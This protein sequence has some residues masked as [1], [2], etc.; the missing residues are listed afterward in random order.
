[1][2][3]A[4]SDWSGPNTADHDRPINKRGQKNAMQVGEWMQKN[5][6]I[7]QKII[8]STCIGKY[9]NIF[10]SACGSQNR[11]FSLFVL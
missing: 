7:P 4:K 5:N 1:M 6:Y 11:L 3:H 10:A 2:R 9:W 8:S